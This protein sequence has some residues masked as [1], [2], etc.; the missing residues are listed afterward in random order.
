MSA[1][2]IVR[3]REAVH[4][5]SDAS[6][7]DHDGVLRY[8]APKTFALPHHPAVI[9][10]RGPNRST[11]IIGAGLAGMFA[12]FDEMVDGIEGSLPNLVEESAQYLAGGGHPRID[13]MIAGWSEREQAPRSFMIMTEENGWRPDHD[14]G[15]AV[16]VQTGNPYELRPLDELV[17]SPTIDQDDIIAAISHGKGFDGIEHMDLDAHGL[18][19]LE[20]QRAKRTALAPGR[21]AHH[22]VGGFA[23]ISTVSRS[24]VSQRVLHRWE[25]QVGETISPPPV[26]WPEWW[27]ERQRRRPAERPG[28]S[29]LQRERME[30]KARKGTLQST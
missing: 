6:V 1:I 22:W 16:S 13:L 9:G 3:Q 5:F 25:D 20:L 14:L 30:K 11:D 23:M 27:K 24:G 17:I 29:R 26:D 2:N 21:D 18:M 10:T 7:Y 8:V 28:V 15:D 12:T 19:L 4:L